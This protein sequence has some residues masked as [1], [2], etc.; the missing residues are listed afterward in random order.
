MT[1]LG[2]PGDDSSATDRIKGTHRSRRAWRGSGKS[3]GDPYGHPI[4][5]VT[6]KRIL[7]LC[8]CWAYV[9]NRQIKLS[10]NP[11]SNK[12]IQELHRSGMR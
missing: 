3:L 12:A 1:L 2:S 7:V 10:S 4:S 9:W 8:V 5:N 6:S 11:V